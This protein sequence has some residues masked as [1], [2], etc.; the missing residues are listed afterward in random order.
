[1]ARF[2]LI[3][4]EGAMIGYVASSLPTISRGDSQ[5]EEAISRADTAGPRPAAIRPISTATNY[6]R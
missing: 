6:T 3:G 1:M 4:F 5:F 2:N